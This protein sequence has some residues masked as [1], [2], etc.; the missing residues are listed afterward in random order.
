MA[1]ISAIKLPDGIT[2]DIADKVSGYITGMTILSYGNSTW[3]E[4]LEAYNLKKVVYC[5]ASSNSTNSLKII[6][7]LGF[8]IVGTPSSLGYSLNL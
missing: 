3:T 6:S 1:N 5:R 8:S 2:Y 7:C 4:F